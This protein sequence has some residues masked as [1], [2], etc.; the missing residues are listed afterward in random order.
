MPAGK[1]LRVAVM[2]PATVHWS[3]DGWQTAQ[4]VSARDT[5]LGIYVADLPISQLDAGR[6]IVFTF[7]WPEA[8]RWEGADFKVVIQESS[9]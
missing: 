3:H 7:Y 5:G 9:K 2:A 1:T 6:T 4:D 8:D